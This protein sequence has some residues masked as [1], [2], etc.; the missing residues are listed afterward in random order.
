MDQS[1][2]FLPPKLSA[3]RRVGSY[4]EH[5]VHRPRTWV[6]F[7][8]TTHLHSIYFILTSLYVLYMCPLYCHLQHAH[9][10]SINRFINSINGFTVWSITWMFLCWLHTFDRFLPAESLYAQYFIFDS[11][12]MLTEAV[13]N[14][15]S[16]S[17]PCLLFC[18]ISG[19]LS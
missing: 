11:T 14:V 13:G 12:M 10:K 9:A 15:H 7:N 16:G 19:C 1:R 8:H 17:L 6:C 2:Q 3:C 4:R 5:L 18:S